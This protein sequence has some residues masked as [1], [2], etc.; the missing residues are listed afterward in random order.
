MTEENEKEESERYGIEFLYQAIGDTQGTIRA[1]DAKLAVVL[2]ILSL[3]F[4]TIGGIFERC[5]KLVCWENNW[6]GVAG[7]ALF[8]VFGVLWAGGFLAA[9]RGIIGIHNPAKHVDTGGMKPKGCFYNAGLYK[10]RFVDSILNRKSLS[11]KTLGEAIR[12][13]PKKEADVLAELEYE[14]MKLVYI[15]DTKQVRQYWAFRIAVLWL[16]TGLGIYCVA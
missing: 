8:T 9:L 3:P 6:S 12:G 16:V 14:H 13:L 5:G 7:L 4:T 15:R 1:I 11:K 10:P 2:V